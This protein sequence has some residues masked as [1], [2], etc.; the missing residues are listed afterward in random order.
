[1]SYFF[2]KHGKDAEIFITDEYYLP[3][4]IWPILL[5]KSAVN[6]CITGYKVS[7]DD[8]LALRV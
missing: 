7:Y 3:G 4:V 8:D 6:I 2:C 5:Y 1:M